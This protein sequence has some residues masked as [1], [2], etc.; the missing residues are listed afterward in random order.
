MVATERPTHANPVLQDWTALHGLPP[1]ERVRP[2][3]F[4]P[5]FQ[6]AMQR[7]RA[8]LDAIARNPAPPDFDNTLAA[9]DAAGRDFRRTEMLFGNLTLSNTSPELQQIERE[10]SQPIAAH[11][12]AIYLH[13]GLFDRIHTLH[14]RRD[15]LGLDEEALRLLDRVHLDFVRAGAQLQ[16]EARARYAKVMEDLSEL[17]TR[18]SQNV[19]ADENGWHLALNNEADFAG[20]PGSV[21]AAA[22]QAAEERGLAGHI[23]TLGRSMVVPF[24][25]FS[26]RRDLREQL[27]CAWTSRGAHAG[28]TDNRDVILRIMKL[29]AE[30]ARLLG[31][32]TYADYALADSMA[33][34]PAA[35]MALLDNVWSRARPAVE[36]ER[37]QLLV[38]QR[39]AGVSDPIEPWDWRFWAEKQRQRQYAIDD[40]E[41]KPYFTLERMVAAAFDCANRLFG[42]RFVPME[43]AAAYHPD[44]KVY[45]V[46]DAMGGMV[47]VFLHDNFA[48]PSKR[49]GAWMS[50]FRQQSK[51][52]GKVLPIVVN[53]NNFN[54]APAGEATL[55]SFDD[56]RTL[57]HEFG[58]G[59][60]GLLSN[61]TF[62]R[63]SGTNVLRDFVE[64]PSQLYEHWIEE[65]EVLRRHAL[66]VHT[67]EPM[68]QALMDRLHAAR[69]F[70]QGFET[71]RYTACALTDLAVH[72]LPLEQIPDDL[73]AF[74]EQVLSERG[75]PPGVGLNHRF[76]HFQHLF[77][78]SSYAAGY[79][80]YL[81]AEVLEADAHTAF[82]EKGDPFDADV[83]ARLLRHI[84]SAGDSVEPGETFAR[85]RGRAP[86]LEPML[87]Q[88]GLLVG[89]ESA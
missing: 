61:V 67:G 33:R 58:H 42:L 7:H 64:L 30:Q 84:Y 20:L 54:K 47:G 34:T 69:K 49:S 44:V 70:A 41:V 88:R 63:L 15:S 14:C 62:Q 25:A 60:H 66:H 24:L 50:D 12:N 73:A 2:E 55:L 48:R 29:R 26:E 75:L 31:F 32:A 68:P 59:L 16:G 83:A 1:F 82:V 4:K 43:C 18:F 80:V 13:Q 77:S 74:E 21:R 6:E 17:S 56:V 10:M 11:F 78:G 72:S 81:W 8:E 85:F 35:A 89:T 36:A 40:A 51:V 46:R 5:A 3:H 39:E 28:R 53:N 52:R 45:E 23:V 79:Y 71:V 57:F 38:L 19:L 37:A 9:F 27:W 76:T 86:R 65:P 87:D 22:R